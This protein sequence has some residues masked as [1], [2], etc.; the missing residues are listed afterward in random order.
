MVKTMHF[1]CR[2]HGFKPWLGNLRSRMPCSMAPQNI[3]VHRV[4]VG[5]AH[6]IN[7][8][9]TY[10]LSRWLAWASS[11]NNSL[12]VVKLFMS[13]LPSPRASVPRGSKWRLPFLNGPSLESSTSSVIFCYSDKSYRPLNFSGRRNRPYFSMKGISKNL[14]SFIMG[15]PWQLRW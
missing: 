14:R 10:A 11:Q 5:S 12:R 13:S 9:P 3:L 4:W 7:V 2:E 8:S 6:I 1:H 15:L